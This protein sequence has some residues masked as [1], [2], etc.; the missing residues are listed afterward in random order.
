MTLVLMSWPGL[1]RV[2]TWQSLGLSLKSRRR[3]DFSWCF[4]GFPLGFSWVCS[5]SVPTPEKDTPLPA[6]HEIL[7][8]LWP[9]H[10]VSAAEVARKWNFLWTC[11]HIVI[12]IYTYI[13]IYIHTCTRTHTHTHVCVCLFVSR[14]PCSRLFKTGAEREQLIWGARDGLWQQR[15]FNR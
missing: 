8:G 14:S 15:W 11:Q 9:R 4:G 1:Q 6:A 2:G 13:Y 12:Q 5:K 10:G 3:S 7:A